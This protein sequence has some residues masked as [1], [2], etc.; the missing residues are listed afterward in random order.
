MVGIGRPHHAGP[1]GADFTETN[2]NNL[3]DADRPIAESESFAKTLAPSG[4]PSI[5]EQADICATNRVKFQQ[6]LW[7]AQSATI[8]GVLVIIRHHLCR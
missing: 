3:V 7:P 5:P 4:N 6:R 2:T 1:V 8:D